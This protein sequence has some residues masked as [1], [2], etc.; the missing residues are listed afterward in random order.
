MS[1]G[2]INIQIDITSLGLVEDEDGELVMSDGL[3]EEIRS[4]LIQRIGSTSFQQN[5]ERE[6]DSAVN[7]VVKEQIRSFLTG[8][9]QRRDRWDGTNIGE[10]TTLKELTMAKVEK[11]LTAP[12]G[13][14]FN[15]QGNLGEMVDA[16]VKDLLAKDL[17]PVVDEAK[18]SITSTLMNAALKGAVEALE[19][20]VR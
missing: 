8:P 6:I 10:P 18:K 9:I 12:P 11:Y 19:P 2:T 14:R 17:K 3:A 13:D 7:E 16:T 4:W 5:V 15:K 20:K 1:K